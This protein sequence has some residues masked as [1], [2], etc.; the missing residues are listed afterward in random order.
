MVSTIEEIVLATARVLII[1]SHCIL[2]DTLPDVVQGSAFSEVAG[3]TSGQRYRTECRLGNDIV[4]GG[5]GNDALHGGTGNDQLFGA[6]RRWVSPSLLRQQYAMVVRGR[7]LTVESP[8]SSG[9]L[10]IHDIK[11]PTMLRTP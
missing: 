6:R 10:A 9:Y 8:T 11:R 1:T 5:E 2:L 7:H 3:F 4:R